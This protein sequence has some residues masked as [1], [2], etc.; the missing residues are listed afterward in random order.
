MLNVKNQLPKATK[1]GK[2]SKLSNNLILMF[3]KL[4]FSRL[5]T[6]LSNEKKDF[7]KKKYC[8]YC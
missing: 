1:K 6:Q 4:I 7:V 8:F 3:T 2:K 5:E